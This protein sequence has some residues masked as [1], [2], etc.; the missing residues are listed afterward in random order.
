LPAGDLTIAQHGLP[1][2]P[3]P[4]PADAPAPGVLAFLGVRAPD[5]RVGPSRHGKRRLAAQGYGFSRGG[6]TAERPLFR[7]SVALEPTVTEVADQPCSPAF[8][9]MRMARCLEPGHDAP[10]ADVCRGMPFCP[11]CFRVDLHPSPGLVLLLCW[12]QQPGQPSHLHPGPALSHRH[13]RPPAA[14]NASHFS[15][16]NDSGPKTGCR[17]LPAGLP[18]IPLPPRPGRE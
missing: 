16:D 4:L 13:A 11:C 1:Y 17:R 7:R 15:P 3:D 10:R 2:H 18:A 9:L 5:R 6:S 8:P 14:V 12:P